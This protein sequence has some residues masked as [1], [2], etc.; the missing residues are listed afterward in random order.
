MPQFEKEENNI[1]GSQCSRWRLCV[2]FLVFS[3]NSVKKSNGIK[4]TLTGT[5]EKQQ[6]LPVTSDY[7]INVTF[8]QLLHSSARELTKKKNTLVID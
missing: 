2:A 3:R 8:C 6:T 7:V 4:V 5:G 1:K